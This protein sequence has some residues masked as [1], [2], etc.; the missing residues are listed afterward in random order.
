MAT[1]WTRSGSTASTIGPPRFSPAASSSGSRWGARWCRPRRAPPGRAVLEPRCEAARGDATEL[2]ELQARVGVTTL[3]VTHDQAEAMVLSD[4][5]IVMNRG[6]IAQDG[7]PREI[8]EEPRIAVRDGVP[9]P[10]RS[11]DG[12]RRPTRRWRV[13]ARR[14]TRGRRGGPPARGPAVAR[15]RAGRSRVPGRRR[16]AG[17]VAADGDWP[18]VIAVRRLSGRARRVRGAPRA[19]HVRASGPV[20]DPLARARLCSSRYPRRRRVWPAGTSP[21]GAPTRHGGGST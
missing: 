13:V 9:G 3:F 15:G 1:L 6:R 21:P 11:P 8:Y 2:K 4:R 20:A 5:I 14:W 7:T 18:G 16:D 19:A 10:G 12:P 17:P